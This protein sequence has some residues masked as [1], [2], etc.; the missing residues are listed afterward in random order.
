MNLSHGAVALSRA[1]ACSFA[2][3]VV[4]VGCADRDCF[5]VPTVRTIRLSPDN[6]YAAPGDVVR[7]RAQLLDEVGD[8]IPEFFGFRPQWQA[9][10]DR[11]MKVLMRDGH[12]V[13]LEVTDQATATVL[14]TAEVGPGATT[15][16]EVTIFTAATGSEDAVLADH[17]AGGLA[18]VALVEDGGAPGWGE[19]LVAFTSRGPLGTLA[20]PAPASP[21]GGGLLLFSAD[22]EMAYAPAPWT[23]SVTG[24]VVNFV[25]AAP[26]HFVGQ[27]L[28][29]PLDV[30][31]HIYVD[32]SAPSDAWTAI[33]AEAIARIHVA[34]AS[35]IFATNRAGVSFSVAE[36][37]LLESVVDDCLDALGTAHPVSSLGASQPIVASEWNVFYVDM[38]GDTGFTCNDTAGNFRIF[39]SSRHPFPT[40][41]AHELGHLLSLGEMDDL[42]EH[43]LMKQGDNDEPRLRRS[44]LSL[45]QICHLNWNSFLK[46]DPRR[47]SPPPPQCPLP[48]ADI[49]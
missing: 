2:F 20:D 9:T 47:K 45:G 17:D 36:V 35:R 32:P 28:D 19:G 7:L 3:A 10:P 43:N 23:A 27:R 25:T 41:L 33:T 40:T 21:P 13:V 31:L 38:G 49:P 48:N 11:A 46:V 16:Q 30:P 1:T 12:T 37:W 44:R 4:A 14:I 24:E 42:G 15:T 8:E 26:G 18:S 5:C 39:I 29:S 34:D 22:R 6:V